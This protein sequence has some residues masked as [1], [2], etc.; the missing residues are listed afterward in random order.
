MATWF[1]RPRDPKDSAAMLSP[2][3]TDSRKGQVR[4]ILLNSTA[5]ARILADRA[6]S[7][8]PVSHPEVTCHRPASRAGRR[9]KIA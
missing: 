4:I 3:Q 7:A 9:G 5:A 6:K 2:P 1:A 8:T